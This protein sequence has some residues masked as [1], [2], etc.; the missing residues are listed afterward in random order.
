MVDK[1]GSRGSLTIRQTCSGM[2]SSSIPSPA[3]PRSG[4]SV[5]PSSRQ[6]FPGNLRPLPS[7]LAGRRVCFLPEDFSFPW[8]PTR[9]Y[10]SRNEWK[11]A[12]KT[13]V[14]YP[15]IRPEENAEKCLY[16]EV[17]LTKITK[18]TFLDLFLKMDSVG[19][20]IEWLLVEFVGLI[21][22]AGRHRPIGAT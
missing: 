15:D 2:T 8:S 6:S 21:Y 4:S 20:R 16:I 14:P 19:S 11:E 9:R 3:S 10:P 1:A 12:G 22:E 5:L 17:R 18:K 7:P 13:A